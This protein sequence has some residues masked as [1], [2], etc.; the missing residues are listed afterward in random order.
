MFKVAITMIAGLLVA[1]VG[2][3]LFATPSSRADFSY[4]N[5]GGINTLDP[6]AITWK[7]DIRIALN[8]WEGLTT[9][10]PRA[11]R[12]VAGAA[13]A[14]DVSQDGLEYTF[15]IRPDAR[16][17]NGDRVTAGDFV[18][19]WRRAI[20]PGTAA[21]YAF[22]ITDHVAGA[23]DY[24][25]WRN[26]SVEKLTGLPAK[27]DAWRAAFEAHASQRDARFANVGI[28]ALDNATFRVRL[29]S[30]C[31]YFLDLC[32]FPT[33]LPI[34]KSIERLRVDH[35]GRGIT[36]GGL[37]TYD[38]Q[39]TKPDYHAK[40]Y[41]GLITNGPFRMS[42]WEFKR[43]VRLERNPFYRLASTVTSTESRDAASLKPVRTVDMLVYPDLNTA[44]MAYE[45]GDLDFLPE[46]NV[47]YDH[48]LTRLATSGARRDFHTAPVFGTYYYVFNCADSNYQGRPNPFVDSRVRKAFALAIDKRAITDKVIGRG[49]PPTGNIV[50]VASI[51]GYASPN[52]LTYD[53]E[54]A[55][56][57]LAD[58]GYPDGNGLG[59]IDLLYS[60]GF[61]HGKVC[62]VLSDMWRQ[63]LGARVVPRGREVKTFSDD[64]KHRRFMI[65]RG[66]W[67]GDYAD[68][69]TFL[70]LFITD[71][72]NN[73]AGYADPVFDEMM[74]RAANT[75]AT[76]GRMSLLAKAESRLIRETLPVLPLFRYTQLLAVKPRVVGLQ[77]NARLIFPFCYLKIKR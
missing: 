10:D 51:A 31:A 70:D 61:D 39:W 38:P 1:T 37:V 52:G 17:S 56:R 14:P 26:E 60:T 20:E 36:R 11:N 16:W 22:F 68:P 32:A 54:E 35:D 12:A 62:D 71:N 6:A 50:P 44:I 34:H 9:Y 53:P 3:F 18:R 57:L 74:A 58:A 4:V 76:D 63:E 64:R 75:R 72:G 42:R 27:S 66:G 15:V 41:P 25:T 28:K 48:E 29:T 19:G 23:A 77:P 47:T 46:T 21:D 73:D 13:N 7:Q 8:I 67:Y 30:P 40:A 59:V 69:T 5:S 49:A 55:R 2:A 33:L 24:Y 65:A 43:R 45:A